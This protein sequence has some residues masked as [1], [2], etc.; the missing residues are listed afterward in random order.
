MHHVTKNEC[1]FFKSNCSIPLIPLKG[2]EKIGGCIVCNP[3][4]VRYLVGRKTETADLTVNPITFFDYLDFLLRG[5]FK[6]F[7]FERFSRCMAKAFRIAG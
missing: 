3:A 2:T 5:F 6:A 1:Y 4:V 7:F